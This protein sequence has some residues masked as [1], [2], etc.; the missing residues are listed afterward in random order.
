[1]HT[2]ELTRPGVKRICCPR[3]GLVAYT[4]I[5]PDVVMPQET[6]LGFVAPVISD[7]ADFQ[8]LSKI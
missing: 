6:C 7:K 1:M 2:G 8:K 5:S 3:L 4:I